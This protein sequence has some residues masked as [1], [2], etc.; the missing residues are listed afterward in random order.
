MSQ[1]FSEERIEKVLRWKKADQEK[2]FEEAF[3]TMSDRDRKRYMKDLDED[4]NVFS[5]RNRKKMRKYKRTR[6]RR[7]SS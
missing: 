7:K 2:W 6:P 3:N 1:D 5:E 4:L